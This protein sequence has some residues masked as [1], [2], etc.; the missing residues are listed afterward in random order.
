MPQVFIPS[1]LTSYTD[2]ASRLAAQGGS[3]AQVLDDLD[4]RYPG[5]KFR[6]VDEQDRIRRHMRIFKNGDRAQDIG[7][8]VSDAD[9]VLIFGALSGG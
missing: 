8:A 9:E 1:Q 2:G 6:V 4:R 5:L 3:I 7:L